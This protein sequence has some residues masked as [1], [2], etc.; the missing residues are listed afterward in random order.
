MKAFVCL[1]VDQWIPTAATKAHSLKTV[2]NILMRGVVP[3]QCLA[4]QNRNIRVRAV[5]FSRNV[6][7]GSGDYQWQLIT[8]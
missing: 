7:N 5:G 1:R 8:R 3:N 2:T 6:I 4:V